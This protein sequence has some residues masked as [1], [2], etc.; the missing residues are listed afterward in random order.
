VGVLVTGGAGFIGSAVAAAFAEAGHDV[1]VLDDLSSGRRENVPAE[2]EFVAGDVADHDAAA[3]AVSGVEQVIH[4]AAHRAVLRSVNDPVATDHANTHG[5]VTLL[6][7]SVDAGVRRFVNVSSSSVYGGATALP[8]PESHPLRPRSP[9]AVS[10]LAG[11]EYARVFA[12]LFGIETLSLRFFNVYGPRQR[13]DSAYAAVIP[14]FI[15]ALH[16]G[17]KPEIHGDGLQSRSF[18]Y[19]DDVVAATFAACAA[20]R[21]ACR[22]QPYNIAGPVTHTVLDVLHT[23]Q[24]LMGSDVAGA[25]TAERA[26]DVRHTWGDSTAATEALGFRASIDLHDGLERTVEWFVKELAPGSH[27]AP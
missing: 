24:S 9:Y 27:P 12:D 6:K 4:L 2:A 25:H 21:D 19:I 23:L 14:L 10:K 26:G 15:R 3:R 11:E 22:G 8:T 18:T 5:T 20:N 7:A 16:D 17:V 1:R 13:P